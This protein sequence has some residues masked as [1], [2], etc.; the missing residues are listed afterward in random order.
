MGSGLS[1]LAALA[2]KTGMTQVGF[3]TRLAPHPGIA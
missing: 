2:S 1:P 3:R